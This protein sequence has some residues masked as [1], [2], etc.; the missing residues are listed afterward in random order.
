[1]FFIWLP[2]FKTVY[3]KFVLASFSIYPVYFPFKIGMKGDYQWSEIY[4]RIII[5]II[6]HDCQELMQI[7]L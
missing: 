4:D 5:C 1:M 2:N 6:D 7:C 3:V